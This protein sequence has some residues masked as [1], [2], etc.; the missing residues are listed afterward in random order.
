M[1][2]FRTTIMKSEIDV[3]DVPNKPDPT[4]LG[5]WQQQPGEG[6]KSYLAFLDY[7][8]LGP[9]AT[10]EQVAEKTGKSIDA[11]WKLSSRHHWL[12]RAAAWR[13]HLAETACIAVQRSV[14]RS[15][16]LWAMRARIIR[17]QQWEISQKMSLV[18]RQLLNS[19]L[20]NPDSKAAVYEIARLFDVSTRLARFASEPADQNSDDLDLQT[21]PVHREFAEAL[22]TAYS[23][24]LPGEL[25]EAGGSSQ[26]P[27][28]P[29][30]PGMAPAPQ[31]GKPLSNNLAERI[32]PGPDGHI[33]FPTSP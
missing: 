13:Q 26:T 8:E 9:E 18:G 16:P 17:E 32:L 7:A 6:L 2:F 10:L 27:P 4:A 19:F 30:A 3:P 20:K 25:P 12:D 22:E 1:A 14:I 24:P 11:I 29:P 5:L 28:N 21:S 15:S 31:P 23:K 33:A